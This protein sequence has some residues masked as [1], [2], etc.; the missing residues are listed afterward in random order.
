[1]PSSR[2]QLLQHCTVKLVPTSSRN[3]GTGLLVTPDTILTCAHVVQG[4]ETA[5][6]PVWW[7]GQA[8]AMARVEQSLPSP[9]DLALL[10][11]KLPEGEQPLCVLLSEAFK[12]FDRLYVYGYPD[13][14]PGGGSVTIRCEG[15]V[16][17][18]GLT[19]IKAQAGQVRP[20][21]SGSPALN[22]ETGQVCGVVSDTRGRSTD[23]GGLLIPV[24]TV[25]KHFPDLQAKTRRL[26]PPIPYGLLYRCKL[27]LHPGG[28]LWCHP[29][30]FPPTILPPSPDA[31]PKPP[32]SP[33]AC[34]EVAGLWRSQA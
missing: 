3:W 14:F 22:W 21:H 11:V 1:M 25:F 23:L 16:H 18:Q 27:H 12:P 30:N 8:W 34:R 9:V 32:R 24:S 17:E 28:G 33:I 7:R 13:D 10:Q 4:Y 6:I 31:R 19:L 29:H 5:A 26:I 20:G 2:D 15:Q